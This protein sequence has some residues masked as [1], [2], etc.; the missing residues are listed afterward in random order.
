MTDY[1]PVQLPAV[2]LA[3]VGRLAQAA[4][5]SGRLRSVRRLAEWVGPSRKVTRSGTLTLADARKA[6]ASR[7]GWRGTAGRPLEEL[8]TDDDDEEVVGVWADR[9]AVMPG[10]RALVTRVEP[11]LGADA[12]GA[13]RCGE[14]LSGG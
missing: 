6:V 4:R 14:T 5:D 1:E 12:D 11:G 2:R 7:R 10:P 9:L 8:Q 3:P 13:E